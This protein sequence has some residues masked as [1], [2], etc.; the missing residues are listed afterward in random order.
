[1]GAES[2]DPRTLQSAHKFHNTP[3]KY[4]EIVRLCRDSGI[5]SHFSNILGFPSDT[6]D[7]IREH[8]ETLRRLAPDV[9][10][11]YLL[12]PIPGT[13]QYEEFRRGGLLTEDN[14]DRY[15]GSSMT[16]RH[17]TLPAARLTEWLF[18]CYRAFYTA[19]DISRKLF[20]LARGRRDFRLYGSLS[21]VLG[22]SLQSRWGARRRLHPMAGGIGP[23]RL[24]RDSDFRNL[25]RRVFGVD[26]A[27]LPDNL[28]LSAADE[29]AN[30]RAKLVV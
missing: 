1:V 7:S 11:F 2:F 8:L 9:A 24:D 3:A 20:R 23:R 25:R 13:E 4:A 10:S 12:T 30:R 28:P 27:P 16:W 19:P 29:D 5:S 26:R 21:A 17:P 22:Y 6:E 18:E 14:L 15:D